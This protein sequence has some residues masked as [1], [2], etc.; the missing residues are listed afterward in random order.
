MPDIP[1]YITNAYDKL[2]RST[3]SLPLHELEKMI[4]SVTKEIE[5]TYIIIDALD[6]CSESTH[7][8]P[9]LM[10]LDRIKKI[11]AVR[12]FVTSRQYPHD[13]RAAFH[14][15]PQIHV[16]AHESDLRRYL[17]RELENASAYDTVDRE[18][19]TNMVNTLIDRAEGM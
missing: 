7:R 15:Q 2:H 10:L 19:A 1:Q 5:R 12:L 8:K 13:I 6:E 3:S 16:Q 14:E 17:Y 11:Q 4:H 9:L 18:F